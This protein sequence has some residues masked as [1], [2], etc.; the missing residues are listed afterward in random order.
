M[1]KVVANVELVCYFNVEDNTELFVDAS[2]TGPTGIGTILTSR[3]RK[4]VNGK[5][6]HVS[7]A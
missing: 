6:L 7:R 5:S 2:P 1:R 4:L 3:V